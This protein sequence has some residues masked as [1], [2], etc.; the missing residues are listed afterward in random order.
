M[1][2]RE[3]EGMNGVHFTSKSNEWETPQDLFDRLNEE[4][5]FT[6]DAA[7]T[8]ENAKCD[9]FFTYIQNGLAQSWE[10]ERVWLNPPYGVD[11]PKW[12]QK[13]ATEPSEVTVMLIPARTDTR[14]WHSF[15]FDR[16]DIRWIKGRV[17][18]SGHKKDAPFA[19]AIVIFRGN[20]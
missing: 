6:L 12:I 18:F 16:A 5:K 19:S 20:K 7:A 1:R 9:R 8:P 13:A 14:A 4:F 17:R 2:D 3:G 15:I 10:G 11:L